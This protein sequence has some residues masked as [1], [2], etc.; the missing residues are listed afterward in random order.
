MIVGITTFFL[1]FIYFRL[2]IETEPLPKM[3]GLELKLQK[4]K[5]SEKIRSEK[6]RIK[7]VNAVKHTYGAGVA[8]YFFTVVYF[9]KNHSISEMNIAKFVAYSIVSF[10]FDG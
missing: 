7:N 2:V 6:A 5:K 8:G 9:N 4:D 10:E 1:C 3:T